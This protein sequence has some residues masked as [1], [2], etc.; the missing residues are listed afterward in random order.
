MALAHLC[1][2]YW[3][4][5][6]VYVRRRGHQPEDTAHLTQACFARFLENKHVC[7]ADRARGRFRSFL[8]SSLQ[9]FLDDEW[10]RAGAAKRG[11]GRL[12]FSWDA[13]QAEARYVREP[14]YSHA[15]HYMASMTLSPI[16][17]ARSV[18]LCR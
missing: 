7:L 16:S 8:L 3:Y 10:D 6:Y 5:L 1:R 9:H 13:A 17:V 18:V 2:K 4:P 15:S 14:K 11:G 12:P